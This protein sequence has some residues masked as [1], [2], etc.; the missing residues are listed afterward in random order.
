[1]LICGEFFSHD[2]TLY[3]DIINTGPLWI[4]AFV[5]NGLLCLNKVLL[6]L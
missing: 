4:A 5:L 2:L 1:M 6:Y 3:F